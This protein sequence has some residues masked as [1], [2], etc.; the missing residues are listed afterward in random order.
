MI[1]VELPTP[2]VDQEGKCVSSIGLQKVIADVRRTLYEDVE[3][4]QTNSAEGNSHL[5]HPVLHR[6]HTRAQLISQ[7]RIF[8]EAA[9]PQLFYIRH[10]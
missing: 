9:T 3:T 1:N 2:L 4:K 7:E 6:C 10:I 8:S 5:H